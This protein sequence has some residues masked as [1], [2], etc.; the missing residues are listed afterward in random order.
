MRSNEQAL[1]ESLAGEETQE[2][3]WTV[4]I[5]TQETGLAAVVTTVRQELLLVVG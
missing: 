4:M 2:L 1:Q 5:Q 3:K